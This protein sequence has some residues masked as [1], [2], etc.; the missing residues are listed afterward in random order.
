MMLVAQLVGFLGLASHVLSFQQARRGRVLLLTMIGCVFWA[1]HFLL[2]GFYT[3]AVINIVVAVRSYVFFKYKDR[4]TNKLLYGFIL[5]CVA[6]TI[7][8]WQGSVSLLP[9][10]A[11]T[12]ST[13]ASWQMFAQRIRWL[14]LPV[15]ILWLAHNAVAGSVPAMIA[16]VSVFVSIAVGLWR[17]RHTGKSA[18]VVR[19]MA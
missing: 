9:L 14:T 17:H 16:D 2:L 13:Y 7:A 11:T 1:T 3:A 18:K 15:P 12:I 5:F 19:E 10:A 8:T 4:R 6:S